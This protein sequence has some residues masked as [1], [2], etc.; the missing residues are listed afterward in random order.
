[1]AEERATKKF[2]TWITRNRPHLKENQL[3]E[4]LLLRMRKEV[5]TLFQGYNPRSYLQCLTDNL[6]TYDSI[7]NGGLDDE[8]KE[9]VKRKG[10]DIATL[11]TSK[12]CV[13][14]VK[15]LLV[16]LKSCSGNI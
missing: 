7:D 10:V 8:W 3:F 15:R 11:T 5:G 13:D 14:A 12:E 2:A 16:L 9:V 6:P 4:K 1:M